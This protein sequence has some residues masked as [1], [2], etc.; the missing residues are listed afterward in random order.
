MPRWP[1][2]TRSTP[3][4]EERAI[5]TSLRAEG[6]W[7]RPGGTASLQAPLPTSD[8]ETRSLMQ[9]GLVALSDFE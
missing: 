7:S 8:S 9:G 3:S 1:P 6:A 4:T 2:K 5:A